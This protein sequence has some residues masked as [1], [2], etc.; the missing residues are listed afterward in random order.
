M[1]S[2]PTMLYDVEAPHAFGYPSRARL[3]MSVPRVTGRAADD[4]TVYTADYVEVSAVHCS[5][6]DK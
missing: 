2:D 4:A 3:A 6:H 5:G 1:T